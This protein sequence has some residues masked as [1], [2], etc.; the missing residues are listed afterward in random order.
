MGSVLPQIG[1]RGVEPPLGTSSRDLLFGPPL[2]T[3]SLDLLFGP[4]LGTSS[5]DLLYGPPLGTSSLD[6]LYGPPLGTSAWDLLFG[7]HSFSR[8]LLR[9][10]WVSE[11][12]VRDYAHL[13]TS[14]EPILMGPP[15]GPL[16]IPTRLG[17]AL[18]GPASIIQNQPTQTS[19]LP[20]LKVNYSGTWKGSGRLPYVNEKTARSKHDTMALALLHSKTVRVKMDGALHYATPLLRIPNTPA[21]QAPKDAVLPRLCAT[22]RRLSKHPKLSEKYQEE[23]NKLIQSV[24]RIPGQQIEQ[25]KETWYLPHHIVEHNDKFHCSFEYRG[26]I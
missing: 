12:R 18:Q 6:L 26:Q 4:R 14:T 9:P 23:L 7:V 21:L 22:E 8:F 5:L 16:A 13:I 17:W 2:W 10:P 15:G 3:S 19:R 11:L 24:K 25:P 20:A 1:E